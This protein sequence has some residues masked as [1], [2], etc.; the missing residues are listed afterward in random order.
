MTMSRVPAWDGFHNTRDLGGL[1]T[2]SG[3]TTR[4]G[5]FFRSGDLRFVT[6]EGWARAHEGGVRTVIDL[7]NA[8][9]ITAAESHAGSA[10]FAG[11]A[12]VTTPAGLERV[13]VPLDDVADVAF[14]EYVNDE[15]LD[16][17]PLYYRPFLERKAERCAAVVTALG[18]SG[19][20]GVVFHCGAG[21]D[22]TGLVALLLL[23][24]ADVEPA[25]IAADYDLSTEAV[26]PLFAALGKEDQGPLIKTFLAN[27]GTT[28]RGA[29][30]A[31]LDGFDAERYL[32][33]AG[34]SSAD[35]AAIR[36]RLLG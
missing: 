32:L 17:S 29:L 11:A 6:A 4:H 31:V 2:T 30:L 24:L 28:V 22:R 19:P 27:R 3:R 35:L 9:E 16:G 1:P 8:D 14:W 25:A 15:Q 10:Q 20:G 12:G 7:R 33:D 5:A 21:R 36:H 34:V 18:R 26:K 23:A 13:E